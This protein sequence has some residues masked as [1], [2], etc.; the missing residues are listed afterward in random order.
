MNQSHTKP[1]CQCM[2]L[3]ACTCMQTG[4]DQIHKQGIRA[5]QQYKPA[6]LS[7]LPNKI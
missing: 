6:Q 1:V 2:P 7:A 5:A 3:R 4:P